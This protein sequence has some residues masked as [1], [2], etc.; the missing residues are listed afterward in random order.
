M[1]AARFVRCW[2]EVLLRKEQS[3]AR[4]L[5][6]TPVMVQMKP[7][8]AAPLAVVNSKAVTALPAMS[9]TVQVVSA[10]RHINTL[11]PEQEIPAMV[12]LH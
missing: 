11:V 5:I 7:V 4:I 9:G 6:N 1:P 12:L 3:S 10:H 2:R 8:A